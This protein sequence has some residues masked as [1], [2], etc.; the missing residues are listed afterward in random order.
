MVSDELVVELAK[1]TQ[2]LV[3]DNFQYNTLKDAADNLFDVFEKASHLDGDLLKHRKDCYLDDGKAIGTYWA[4]RCLT[5]F[6]RTRKFLMGI[7]D[8]IKAL[9]KRFPNEV[10]HIL[11]AGTG[12][13]ATLITP[14]TT[15]FDAS[16]IQITGLEIN[17]ESI[18]CLKEIIEAFSIEDYFK[19]I[20]ECDATCYQ[21]NKNEKI[22]MIIT[23][24]ML[25]GLQK[26]PQVA[27]VQNLVPQLI[28]GGILI[29]Q[30]IALSINLVDNKAKIER[31]FHEISD[32]TPFFVEVTSLINL[33]QFNC[34]NTDMY[35][36]IAVR[37]NMCVEERFKDVSMFTTIQVYEKHFIGL[38]E[39]S[40]TIPI[41]IR[42]LT[43]SILRDQKVVFNYVFGERPKF[44][45]QVI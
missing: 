42:E 22:H 25:N 2:I 28:D 14:L 1:S 17:V 45:Y 29:P 7:H 37:L 4:G 41:A 34:N 40:L 38:N 18:Q 43:Q 6:M 9:Q 31:L 44:E 16:E 20:V 3:A 36:N 10:I 24:T 19:K 39:C 30:N 32:R 5:E 21:K 23:E 35:N 33:N 8:G 26:E 12:P 13:F 11:Y 15:I 27:I